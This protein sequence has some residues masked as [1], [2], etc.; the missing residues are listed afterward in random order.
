MKK[1]AISVHAS[2]NFLISPLEAITG[3]DYIHIDVMDGKFVKSVNKETNVFKI[4]HKRLKYPVIAHFMVVNPLDW[5]DEAINYIDY[6]LF[7]Y[8]IEGEKSKIINEIR[9][10]KKNVGIVINPETRISQIIEFLDKIDLVLI[11]GVNPGYSGQLFIP[12]TIKKVN[13]LAQYK[14]DFDFIIDVDGGINLNN[15]KRL[16]NADILT[17]SSTILKS[18]NPNQVIQQLKG[19]GER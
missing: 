11:L 7:H 6:F 10:K 16:V 3:F 9:R 2:N 1:V 12:D 5:I 14:K 4:I 19:G 8:E 17:S 15:A 18:H 13:N